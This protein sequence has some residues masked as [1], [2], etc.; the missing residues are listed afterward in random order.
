MLE[1]NWTLP[2]FFQNAK[3]RLAVEAENEAMWGDIVALNVKKIKSGQGRPG[4]EA[5]GIEL[6][7]YV[8]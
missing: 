4:F 3:K 2:V 6:N 5:R 8:T 1:K 7:F